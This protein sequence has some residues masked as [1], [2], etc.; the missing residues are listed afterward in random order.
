MSSAPAASSRLTAIQWLVCIIAAIGFAF[1]TYE[2]LML[3]LI[4]TPALSELLKVPP[5][6]PLVREWFG[7]MQWGSALCGG[8]FGLLG[9]WLIDRFGRKKVLLASIVIYGFSPVLAAM[10]TSVTQLFIFRCTTFIGV[11][12]EFVAAIAWL[13]ELFPERRQRETVLGV[14]QAFASFGGLMVTSASVLC[15][16]FASSLPALPVDAPLDG[17]AFWRYTLIT[18]LIPAIPTLML[19][20]F[21]P[22]SPVWR[23]K[24]AAGTL[25]RPS[26]AELFA[27]AFRR[28]TITTTIL[29]ACC[30]GAA[31]G[32]IQLTPPIISRG[33]PEL[34]ETTAAA[35]PLIEKSKQLNRQLIEA[36]KAGNVETQ[37][38]LRSQ[39]AANRKA[40][41]P[42]LDRFEEVKDRMQFWQ[43]TGGLIGRIALAV[44]AVV[45]ISKRTLLRLFVVPGLVVIPLTF[46]YFAFQS[47]LALQWSLG[48]CAFLTVA[49]FSYW[50]NYLPAAFPV[51]L[52]GTAGGFAANVGGRMIGTFAALVTTSWVAPHMPGSGAAQTAYGAAVVGGSVYLIALIASFC[53]PEPTYAADQD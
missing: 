4:S 53:L 9:G 18:G 46:G 44:L 28:T 27:P 8:V 34:A 48:V 10:S 49:Q 50:G 38:D 21:L 25:K 39:I 31:F 17:H 12:V 15:R 19:L 45:I 41:K 2:L 47:E 26:F 11:C 42:Y 33:V 14:T 32:A 40:A 22:E 24:R 51:H 1:D 36:Q 43:E 52:R 3:P 13:A 6:N 23:A 16:N 30:Y 20:P 35:D 7:Y 5:D 29:F 37:K